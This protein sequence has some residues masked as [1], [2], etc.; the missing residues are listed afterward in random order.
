MK[1]LSLIARILICLIVGITIGLICKNFEWSVPIRILVTLSGLFGNFLSFVIPLIIIG[2]IIPGIASL[3]NK[4]GKGLLVTTV[5][6]YSSTILAGFF[7]YLVG[8]TLLPKLIKGTNMFGEAGELVAPYFNID[9]PPIMGVM[10]ALVL[11]FVLGIGLSRIKN[12]VLLKGV[13]ELNELVLMVVQNV[14][15][16]LVP[17]YIGCIFAKLSFSG[18]I[19]TTMKSFGSVYII[20]LSLQVIYIVFQYVIAGLIK[21]DSP[22]KMIKNMMPAYLTAVGTQSSAATIPVTLQCAMKNNIR[23]EVLDFVIPLGA[24]IH[25]AGDTITLVLTSMA[26]MYMRGQVPTFEGMMPFVLMLGVIMIAAPGV[27]GGG[28]MAALGLLESMLGF[29]GLEKP[30]MIALHAAQDSFGTATNIT[31]D[32]AVAAIV[33]AILYEKNLS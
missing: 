30:L 32:G 29:G 25:L 3:G 27:P 16:P 4:S 1:K 28:V 11:A 7:A 6:A 22:L 14:L 9:M 21:K 12:S 2:F 17:L 8:N 5:V 33:E 13:E 15:I 19:L 20:L 18:E 24:T 10:S 31:G 23:E 26:V